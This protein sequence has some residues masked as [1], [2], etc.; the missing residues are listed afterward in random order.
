MIGTAAKIH[1]QDFELAAVRAVNDAGQRVN[2]RRCYA[3]PIFDQADEAG[4]NLQ[5]QPGG[6]QRALPRLYAAGRDREEVIAGI[7]RARRFE[8]D[9]ERP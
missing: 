5:M 9:V 3:R 6:D 2:A 4:R 7:T 8:F 1:D